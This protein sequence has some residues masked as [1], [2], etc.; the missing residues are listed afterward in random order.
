MY[1]QTFVDATSRVEGNGPTG[2]I[3]L[4][5]YKRV[6]TELQLLQ[7]ESIDY[8]SIDKSINE[9]IN[10]LT[11][12]QDEALNCECVVLATILNPRFRGKF[13]SIHYP[14]HNVSANSIIENT[15]EN[16]LKQTEP[17]EDETL[18]G[19]NNDFNP[20]DADTFDIFGVCNDITNKSSRTSELSN[21]LK[22]QCPIKKEQTPLTWWKVGLNFIGLTLGC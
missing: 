14:E 17:Q 22:G 12:Y 6:I 7:D 3:L 1:V 13:F 21:Y 19:S 2:C 15:F 5:E 16:A 20:T 8:P 18:D 11:K 4:A 9:M 10:W